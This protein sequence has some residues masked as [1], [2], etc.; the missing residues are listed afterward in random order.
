MNKGLAID[1]SLRGAFCAAETRGIFSSVESLKVGHKPR[2][3]RPPSE[4]EAIWCDNDVRGFGE[5]VKYLQHPLVGTIG[6]EY[7]A[8]AVDGR[9]NLGL[10]IYQP[11]TPADED[12]IRTL[13]KALSETAGRP[14]L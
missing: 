4:F 8:F 10:V 11:V 6:W 7:S 1:L 3:G 9:S 2:P 12:R 14:S 13:M 5:G